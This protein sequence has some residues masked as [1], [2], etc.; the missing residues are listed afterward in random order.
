MTAI[1]R[2]SNIWLALAILISTFFSA[3]SPLM[4]VSRL[5]CLGAGA[6]EYLLP[7]SGYLFTGQWDKSI[8]LGGGRWI[9]GNQYY[10]AATSEYY[11]E[12]RG[13]IYKVIEAEDSESEKTEIS[14]YL[15]K[16]TWQADFYGNI[17]GNLLF[18]TWGDMYQHGCQS[19]TETYRWMLSPFRFDHF[20][21][22]WWFWVPFVYQMGMYAYFS[23]Y[24]KVEYHLQRGLRESDLK[25]TA[26]PE[27]YMIGVGEEMFFRGTVQH[28]LF[29]QLD[30]FWGFSP[31]ASRYLSIAGASAIFAAAHDGSGFT[32][33]PLG[34][35]FF[36][37]YEGF[38]YHPSIEE[39]DLTTAIAI[40]SWWDIWV[41]YAILNHAEFKEYDTDARIPVFKIGFRF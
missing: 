1:C 22:K 23:D 11:Q 36:G 39:F 15:N 9:A 2:S 14:I 13:D 27:N 19:N 32:A 35:F 21:N 37:I 4:A 29:E 30:N 28:Y 40:H 16:E 3:N 26:F 8:I 33:S 10:Q 12:D 17:Y 18:I 38:V 31:S 25:Q 5:G 34:A 41:Y 20:Y 7:G 24:A 6:A